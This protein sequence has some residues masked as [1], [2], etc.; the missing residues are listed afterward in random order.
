MKESTLIAVVLDKSG[1]MASLANDVIGSFNKFLN[2]QK[3][4][5]TAST[6]TC[7]F[8][9]TMFDTKYHTQPLTDL[10]KVEELNNQT[11]KPDGCTA[12]YDA[13]GRTIHN[14]GLTLSSRNENDKPNKVLI[15]IITDGE[16][17][18]STEFK[19]NQIKEMITHQKEKYNWEFLFLAANQDAILA[20][21]SIGIPSTRSVSISNT[22]TG[23]Y[24]SYNAI[25]S[26]TTS[27]RNNQQLNNLGDLYHDNLH[28]QSPIKT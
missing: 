4:L 8:T 25:S 28:S 10:Q 27:F 11:Y 21:G 16:E 22:P 18:S 17:N 7:E 20:G 26:F 13:I 3:S 19:Q 12:L 6:Q 1:S 23:Y 9:I 14:I 5:P 15:V 2:E 24:A